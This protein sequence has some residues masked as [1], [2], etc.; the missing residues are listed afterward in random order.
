MGLNQRNRS[1]N[2]RSNNKG[3]SMTVK[4]KL[5]IFGVGLGIVVA[6]SLFF[7]AFNWER[8]EGNERLVT[9]NWNT[10]VS[11]E[12]ETSGTYFYVPLTTS[13]YKY[14]IGTEKFIMGDKEHYNGA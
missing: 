7:M 12:I 2:S 5:T 8:V 11:Q 4:Q 3:T 6:F 13:I 1:T 9:Q 14:N 10:G